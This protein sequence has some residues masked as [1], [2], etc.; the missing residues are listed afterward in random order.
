MDHYNNFLEQVTK[1]KVP[2][3]VLY[4]SGDK[5]IAGKP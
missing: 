3:Q 2:T 1:H 5:A 4:P